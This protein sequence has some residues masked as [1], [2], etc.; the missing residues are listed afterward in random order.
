VSR[1]RFLGI[2]AAGAYIA[3]FGG[4]AAA[5]DSAV[6]GSILW[7]MAKPD[8][9]PDA[10]L[11]AALYYLQLAFGGA[12]FAVPFGLLLAGVS[13]T[14]GLRKL[15]PQWVVAVG[16]ALAFVGELSWFSMIL[17]EVGFLIP[18]TRLPGFVWL[19]A[20]GFALPENRSIR[21][22]S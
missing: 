22:T 12:G 9:R 13:I 10:P 15:L 2:T 1:L 6:S 7:A 5:L 19:I 11:L 4:I 17:P 20:T 21:E 14:A 16:L 8:S 3:L 18:L